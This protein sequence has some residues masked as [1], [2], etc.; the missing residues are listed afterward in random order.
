MLLSG[1]NRMMGCGLVLGL[2]IGLGVAACSDEG[3]DQASPALDQTLG[4]VEAGPDDLGEQPTED[5]DER[6]RETPA[7]AEAAAEMAAAEA[8]G[9]VQ[10]A[11]ENAASSTRDVGSRARES[12]ERTVVATAESIE[13]SIDAGPPD[14]E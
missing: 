14:R 8:G 1:L 3:V 13:A 4:S 7:F 6:S 11:A 5:A 12:A 9:S 2:V 10:R